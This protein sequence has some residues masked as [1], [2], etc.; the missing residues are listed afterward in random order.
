[1]NEDNTVY[2]RSEKDLRIFMHPLRQKILRILSQVGKP[3]TA[4]RLADIL[5]ITHSSAK[6]HLQQLESIGLVG[7]HHTEMIRGIRASFYEVL[8][9][10]VSLSKCEDRLDNEKKVLLQNIIASVFESYLDKLDAIGGDV[11]TQDHFE[12]DFV[13]GVVHVTQEQADQIYRMIAD[14]VKKN[15][16]GGVDTVP[17]EYV[18]IAY[19]VESK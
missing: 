9:K 1:M 5:E 3:V 4:K 11:H 6:Y 14:F 12:A 19:K 18:L 17:Y 7:L 13:S 10:T 15:E 8:P 2:I 16:M